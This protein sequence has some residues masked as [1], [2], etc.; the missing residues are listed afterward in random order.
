MKAPAHVKDEPCP[1]IARTDERKSGC[2]FNAD[3][4]ASG[5]KEVSAVAQNK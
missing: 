2:G 4:G 1:F 3:L 5:T